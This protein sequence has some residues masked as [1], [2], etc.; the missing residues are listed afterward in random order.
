MALNFPKLPS[1][2][3]HSDLYANLKSLSLTVFNLLLNPRVVFQNLFSFLEEIEILTKE[4]T[5]M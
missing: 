3:R 4:I 1:R 2:G 5:R